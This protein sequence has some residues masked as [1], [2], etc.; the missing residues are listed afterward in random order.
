[1]TP[2]CV[3]GMGLSSR[4]LTQEHFRIIA[5][6]DILVAGKRHL[7]AF[8]DVLTEKVELSA[9][10]AGVFDFIRGRMENNRIVV[11][12]SGDPLFYGIGARLVDALG[13]ENIVI[14]PNITTVAGAFARIKEPWQD[15][16][17][18]SLH[19]RSDPAQLLSA[20]DAADRIAVFTDPQRTPAWVARLLIE[21]RLDAFELCVCERLGDPSERVEWLSPEA[22]AGASF[23]EPNLVVLKRKP[24]AIP[25]VRP[26]RLG[27]PDSAYEHSAGMITKAEVRAVTLSRLCLQPHHVLW[28]L[29]AGSGSI[30]IEASLFVRSGRIV[31]V[32]KDPERIA[33]IRA[34]QHRFGVRNLHIVQSVL[35]DGLDQLPPPDRIFIGGGGKDLEP[36]IAAA[37]SRI[38]ENGRM[39]I[40]TVLLENMASA[41]DAL[42][43]SGFRTD[44]VQIQ[45]NRGRTMPW[46]ERLKAENPVWIISGEG[47]CP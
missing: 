30:S 35:P 18:V 12:A 4:N 15:A 2:V 22:A 33:D 40:N 8:P 21:H 27:A 31:A 47:S 37:A 38:K 11:L 7:E 9:N 23:L 34:N 6:A 14:Y 29:G 41:R 28:D 1:M 44:V 25:T 46:G 36:I 13:A 43:R 39:V 42:R 10:L 45:V 16:T 32:E 26:V 5:E 17:V 20:A 19:G 24:G 3:I